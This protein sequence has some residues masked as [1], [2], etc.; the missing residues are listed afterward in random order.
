DA[1]SINGSDALF[2]ALDSS[3]VRY[4]DLTNR[5]GPDGKLMLG[6]DSSLIAVAPIEEV[7]EKSSR[8][9]VLGA[10]LNVS[11]SGDSGLGVGDLIAVFG[12]RIAGQVPTA[13][14]IARIYPGAPSYSSDVFVQGAVQKVDRDLGI[15]KVGSLFIDYNAQLSRQSLPTSRLNLG[16]LRV[17]GI[18]SER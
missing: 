10:S 2:A 11:L 17:G 5:V 12:T 16:D 9:K 18:F 3:I 15:V 6:F 1:L 14:T 13:T 8:V 4:V 7:G